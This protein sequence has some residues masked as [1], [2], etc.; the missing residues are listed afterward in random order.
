[1]GTTP[2][3]RIALLESQIKLHPDDVD[4]HLA[5]VDL[6]YDEEM[7]QKAEKILSRLLKRKLGS[8][9]QAELFYRLGLI[10]C[11]QH[12]DE[13]A[14][15]FAEKAL[16]LDPEF[17]KMADLYVLLGDAYLANYQAVRVPDRDAH[18]LGE[19]EE[20]F[21]K[22]TD[23]YPD[24]ENMGWVYRQQGQCL[25]YKE[26]YHEAIEHFQKA[27]VSKTTYDWLV[28][29]LYERLGTLHALGTKQYDQAITFFQKALDEITFEGKSNW[30]AQVYLNMS[31]AY[32]GMEKSEEA[33]TTA[34]QAME[35][36]DSQEYDYHEALASV[37]CNLGDALV[38]FAGKE[39]EAMQHY[40]KYLK[41]VKKER[42][43]PVNASVYENLGHL[44]YRKRQYARAIKMLRKALELQ[45][46]YPKKSY[47]SYV[48]G[49]CYQWQKKPI[50]A[51]KYYEEA[52]REPDE[53]INLFQLHRGLGH[54]YFALS[55]YDKAAQHFRE[56]LRIADPKAKQLPEIRQY[57]FA[58]NERAAERSDLP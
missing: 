10:R 38:H 18:L 50:D 53:H 29:D 34:R 46:D 30:R 1:M 57:L 4:S 52:L 28:A 36:L 47:V 27:L 41:L 21:K 9:S 31:R 37:H 24:Y 45:P 14:L 42:D 19:A 5:L 25:R 32:A 55:L 51:K 13:E 40:Q 8:Q 15:P 49:M 54:T 35:M 33:L 43:D 22:V 16:E 3:E 17:S 26:Q 7:F 12:R 44:Y 23:A 2:E 11:K 20:Y 56:A 39:D 48:I 6:Y 58:A